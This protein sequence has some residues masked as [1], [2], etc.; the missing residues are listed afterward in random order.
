[1]EVTQRAVR[2]LHSQ[3]GVRSLSHFHTRTMCAQS[4][5]VTFGQS[6]VHLTAE[7]KI[8]CEVCVHVSVFDYVWCETQ[9]LAHGLADFSGSLGSRSHS[10][11]EWEQFYED[12]PTQ[13]HIDY[14][15]A[16]VTVWEEHFCLCLTLSYSYRKAL[17]FLPSFLP[18]LQFNSTFS[19]TS[20]KLNPLPIWEY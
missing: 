14:T 2:E 18:C 7:W 17:S 15:H 20:V 9:C 11:W 3:A 8:F 6:W 19:C 1:M 4:P 16:H 5:S 13:T 12:T 10:R